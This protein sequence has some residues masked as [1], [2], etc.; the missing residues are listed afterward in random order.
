[1]KSKTIFPLI[2]LSILIAA[3]G[4]KSTPTPAPVATVLPTTNPTNTPAPMLEP[5]TPTPTQISLNPAAWGMQEIEAPAF[6]PAKGSIH[7]S[8]PQDVAQEF[9]AKVM[10]LQHLKY[11]PGQADSWT[12]PETYN[13]VFALLYPGSPAEEDWQEHVDAAIQGTEYTANYSA[14]IQDSNYYTDWMAWAVDEGPNLGLLVMVHHIVQPLTV[15]YYNRDSDVVKQNTRVKPVRVIIIYR[16]A[17]DGE[18]L[19]WD[20]EADV[21]EP[22]G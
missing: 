17:P 12:D 6:S 22:Q 10:T 11:D 9:I 4:P 21:I 7:Y 20:G 15:T 19:K 18:W 3:C 16:R 2:A 1:M 14:P 8:L 5:A 13:Q